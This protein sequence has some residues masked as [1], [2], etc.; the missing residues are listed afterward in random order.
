MD[1]E[2]KAQWLADLRSSEYVQGT[3]ALNRNG[4][5]CCLGVLTDQAVKAGITTD[6]GTNERGDRLYGSSEDFGNASFLP[7]EVSEWAGLGGRCNPYVDEHRNLASLN[8][9]GRTF[10]EIADIIEQ[11]F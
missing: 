9:E 3:G 4:Q 10:Q 7:P 1:Q 5:F 6:Q 8:D 2:I 11:N